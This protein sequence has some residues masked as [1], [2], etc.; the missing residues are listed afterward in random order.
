MSDEEYA[1]LLGLVRGAAQ[2]GDA[3]FPKGAYEG[4][5]EKMVSVASPTENVK[6]VAKSSSL[7]GEGALTRFRLGTLQLPQT[8]LERIRLV[9][10]GT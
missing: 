5:V 2:N 10:K 1:R 8:L 9:L 7:D 3:R 4:D 6:P